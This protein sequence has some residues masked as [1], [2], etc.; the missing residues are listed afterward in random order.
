MK[1]IK[2]GV[3]YMHKLLCFFFLIL[4]IPCFSLLAEEG[5]E[6]DIKLFACKEAYDKSS[7]ACHYSQERCLK[8]PPMNP[9]LCFE[10]GAQ[11]YKRAKKNYEG[12]ILKQ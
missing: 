9:E 3:R 7:L 4:L 12:C 2:L 10:W 5:S 1:K 6:G 11:C 8:T